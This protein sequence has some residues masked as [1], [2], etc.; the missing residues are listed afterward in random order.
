MP[1]KTFPVKTRL[2]PVMIALVSLG[3]AAP[4]LSLTIDFEEFTH[5]DE[6]TSSQGVTIVTT[7]DNKAWDQGVAF[8]T[9]Q[10]GT[11][12]EDLQFLSPGIAGGH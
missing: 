5:G 2:A 7:N 6:V 10:P 9:N 8:D 1:L 3:V 4:A 11:A 12:D